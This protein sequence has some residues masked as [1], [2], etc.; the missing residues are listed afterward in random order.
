MLSVPGASS[1]G[2]Q[3]ELHGSQRV[4]RL[5]STQTQLTN[6]FTIHGMKLSRSMNAR[7]T[8]N[9]SLSTKAIQPNMDVLFPNLML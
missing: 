3:R 1:G 7:I 5:P 2:C 4:V 8:R 6:V 9:T